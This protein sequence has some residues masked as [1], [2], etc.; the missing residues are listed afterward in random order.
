MRQ[1]TI[2]KILKHLNSIKDEKITIKQY[3]DKNKIYNG[4]IYNYIA[5]VKNAKKYNTIE[6]E[7]YDAIMNLYNSIIEKSPDAKETDNRAQINI[8]RDEN[9]RISSY[10]FTIY[11]KDKEPVVGQL[12][13]DEMALIYRLYSSYG[14]NIT[15]REVSRFFPEY[16]LCDFKRILRTFS[17]TKASAP[18]PPHIVEEKSKEE[19]LDMQFREKEN[20]FLRSYEVEK[21][22]QMDSQLKKY[23]KEN[24]D[25][26]D[27]L[28]SLSNIT[29][30][31]PEITIAPTQFTGE[32][33]RDLLIYL[34][35]MHIGAEVGN[36]SLYNNVYNKEEVNRRLDK[37]FNTVYNASGYDTIVVCNAGDSLDGAYNQTTR[38]GHYLPQNMSDKEQIQ[39]FLD[40]MSTFFSKLLTIPHNTIKYYAVGESNHGGIYEYASQVALSGILSKLGIEST[41]FDKFLGT[42]E[43]KGKYYLLSHGKDD[44]DMFKNW[45]LVLNDKT[46][47]IINEYLDS[48]GIG[49]ATVIK[50]DLHQSAITYGKRIKYHSVGS[51]FGSSGWIM[52]NFGNTKAACDYSI[53]EDDKVTDGRVILN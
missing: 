28:N 31:I 5:K 8:N 29:V 2:N 15:Q 50:G 53:V 44:K 9:G 10:G 32:P 25:L 52:K 18:F 40:C 1:E 47:G 43:L 19:L 45:P 42:F 14:S 26:K 39:C 41:I 30:E 23:M 51:L 20:D 22:K 12:S 49:N 4:F 13:R 38:T 46:E 33:S 11:V 36:N 7:D 48:V 24:A 34:S 21:I 16:S 17:I 6:Q 27:Q 37:V 3:E 35:D